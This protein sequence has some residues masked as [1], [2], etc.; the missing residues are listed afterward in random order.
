MNHFNFFS[1]LPLRLFFFIIIVLYFI[2]I[3]VNLC[4]FLMLH[5]ILFWYSYNSDYD[6]ICEYDC[7]LICFLSSSQFQ[8]NKKQIFLMQYFCIIYLFNKT[9]LHLSKIQPD[10]YVL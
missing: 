4:L 10:P 8:L 2:N 3:F 7:Y 1:K 6:F 5:S 9:F